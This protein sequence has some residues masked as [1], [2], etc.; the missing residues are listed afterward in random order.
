L[1]VVAGIIFQGWEAFAYVLTAALGSSALGF[2]GGHLLS[3]GAIEGLSGSLLEQ[4]SKRLA[5][6]GTV[7]VALLRL[8]PIAP[9]AVFNLVAGASH[10]NFRQFMVGSLLGLAPGLGAITLFSSTLWG[11][12]TAPSWTNI[13]VAVAL[14]GA[15]ALLAWQVKRWLRSG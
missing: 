8:V 3:R 2:V 6:R 14:G 10:L 1:A 5:E 15:L 12:I 4:L 11:A 9:F 13:A 7:A